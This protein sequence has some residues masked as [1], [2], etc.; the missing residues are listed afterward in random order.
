MS[1][2]NDVVWSEWEENN[3][4]SWLDAGRA[5]PWKARSHAYYEQYQMDRSV[6]SL[7][8]KKYHILR[9][10]RRTVSRSPTLP[11]NRNRAGAI[12]RSVGRKASLATLPNKRPTQSNRK[13][14]FQTVLRTEPS[15]ID[16]IESKKPK[17]SRP[18]MNWSAPTVHY[19]PTMHHRPRDAITP[20]VTAWRNSVVITDLG[21]CTSC[22]C[23]Q[24]ARLSMS[25][26]S[27]LPAV[28]WH[29]RWIMISKQ[30]L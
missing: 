23:S 5:L 2:R 19:K 9:K 15:Y 7:R 24:E 4:L 16:S 18:G 26:A 13:S 10:Q 27:M 30:P 20:P 3:L 6:E 28:R 25:G 1:P 14:L 21:L 17:G 29:T 12:R 11:T 8:G 22:L